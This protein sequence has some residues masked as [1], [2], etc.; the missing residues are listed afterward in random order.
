MNFT[1]PQTNPVP[2]Y[3]MGMNIFPPAP[4]G[5]LTETYAASLPPGM[6]ISAL[7]PAFRTA[8]VSQWN[9]SIYHSIGVNDSVELSYLGSSSSRLPVNDDIS[10]CRPASNLYCDPA[11]K[12][13]PRY[14]LIYFATSGG[15]ASYEAGVIR[16][17]H[18]ASSG[19]NLRFEYTLGKTLTDAWESGLTAAAQI[20]N[21]RRCDKGPATF[22]VRSRA[23]AS[24][25]WEI[26]YGRGPIAGGWSISAIATFA[27]GQPILLSG[28]NQTNTL[29]LNHLPNRVCDGRSDRLAANIRNNDFLWFSPTCFPVPPAG[30][31]G[32]SGAT[33]LNGPGLNNW[34][35]STVKSIALKE[36]AKLQLRAEMFNVWN[37][38]Q[39]QGPDSNAGDGANFGRISA[40]RP[41]RLIQLAMKVLW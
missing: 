37:H 29:F 2:A 30:Y 8:Y 3:R 20:T 35:V 6:S 24:L 10:Q 31:F 17:S 23:V 28:P 15:N 34:D 21:C 1:N 26:P 25:V 13:W 16:Y 5:P 41:P 18:R 11:T 39:F 9:F 27:T 19:L 38:A 32:D 14:P 40:A 33:V 7:D 4:G 22:D 12:P 36:V